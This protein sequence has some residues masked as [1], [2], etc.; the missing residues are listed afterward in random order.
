MRDARYDAPHRIPRTR[1][2][3]LP[4]PRENVVAAL[5]VRRSIRHLRHLRIRLSLNTQ[6]PRYRG[7]KKTGGREGGEVEIR[8]RSFLVAPRCT[9]MLMHP[10][11]IEVDNELQ[12]RLFGVESCLFALFLFLCAES[13][14]LQRFGMNERTRV[15]RVLEGLCG[16]CSRDVKIPTTKTL[17]AKL[18]R[19][20]R[21]LSPDLHRARHR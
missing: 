5:G 13:I 2:R 18:S 6:M 7:P 1:T 10:E 17:L 9:L 4:P 19:N 12:F 8:T 15:P 11:C 3:R 21:Q 14:F 20:C 16:C